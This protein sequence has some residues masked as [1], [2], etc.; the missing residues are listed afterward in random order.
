MATNKFDWLASESAPNDYP[1]KIISGHFHDPD[2]GSLYVPNGKL[3]YEGWG[4]SLY[5]E[6]R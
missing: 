1:M 3:I 5:I 4:L 6:F 2:G